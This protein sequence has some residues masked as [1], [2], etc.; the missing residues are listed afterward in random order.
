MS[1]L[2]DSETSTRWKKL[3]TWW[4][5]SSH[6]ISCHNSKN[7]PQRNGNKP[8]LEL[9]VNCSLNNQDDA[10]QITT[11]PISRWLSELTVLFLHVPTPSLWQKSSYPLIDGVGSCPLNMSSPPTP[12]LTAS[13]NKQ[14]SLS[15]NLGS[16]LALEQRATGGPHF[17][18]TV[19]GTNVGSAVF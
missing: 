3:I 5:G 18:L 15:T 19:F 9:Q 10:D 4:P 13:E 8:I 11:W 16:L 12:L 2:T 1:C 17:W 7:W 14:T 6:D